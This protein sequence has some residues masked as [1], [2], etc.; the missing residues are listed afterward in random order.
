[1][2]KKY[3]K[4]TVNVQKVYL[5]T[6]IAAGSAVVRPENGDGWIQEEWTEDDD[7]I[8]DLDW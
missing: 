4:P 5:E 1:M 7:Q 6:G 2:K 8:R 3:F